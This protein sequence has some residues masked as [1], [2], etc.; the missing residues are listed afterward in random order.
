[1][2]P[3]NE[4]ATQERANET[5]PASVKG[6]SASSSPSKSKFM[7]SL[8]LLFS[9]K[10]PAQRSQ[11][12]EQPQPQAQEQT[13]AQPQEFAPNSQPQSSA[14]QLSA[15]TQPQSQTAAPSQPQPQTAAP[16]QPRP[17]AQVRQPRQRAPEDEDAESIASSDDVHF[18][19]PSRLVAHDNP[20]LAGRSK[21]R[22]VGAERTA[23]TLQKKTNAK[24]SPS[25]PSVLSGLFGSRRAES[26]K[27]SSLAKVET[28]T[29]RDVKSGLGP[30]ER[31]LVYSS[32]DEVGG[33]KATIYQGQMPKS[34]IEPVD[35]REVGQSLEARYRGDPGVGESGF[36]AAGA[37]VPLVPTQ[38]QEQEQ[39]QQQQKRVVKRRGSTATES[40]IGTQRES[41]AVSGTGRP[42]GRKLKKSRTVTGEGKEAKGKSGAALVGSKKV[43]NKQ[44]S[45]STP[46]GSG[47]GYGV[48][49]V[50]GGD[51]Q[52][53]PAMPV[54]APAL[55]KPK[56]KEVMKRSE[57]EG[58]GAGLV[59]RKSTVKK[60]TTAGGGESSTHP[61]AN[62]AS[63]NPMSGNPSSYHIRSSSHISAGSGLSNP[64]AGNAYPAGSSGPSSHASP[65]MGI[66]RPGAH[67]RVSA[68]PAHPPLNV[69]AAGVSHPGHSHPPAVAVSNHPGTSA[70][71]HHPGTSAAAPPRHPARPVPH[72]AATVS[73]QHRPPPIVTP[74]HPTTSAPAHHAATASHPSTSAPFR[75]AVSAAQPSSSAPA[76]HHAATSTAPP[77]TG[78]PPSRPTSV[79]AHSSSTTV[80]VLPAGGEHPSGTLSSGGWGGS[81]SGLSRQSSVLSASSAPIGV[82]RGK[83]QATLGQGMGVGRRASVG[84]VPKDGSTTPEGQK[85]KHKRSLS[86]DLGSSTAPTFVPV[87]KEKM[88]P[89]SVKK[90]SKAEKKPSA[91]PRGLSHMQSHTHFPPAGTTSTAQSLM[92]IVA[93]VARGNRESW[94][95]GEESV[96]ALKYTGGME[97][98]IGTMQVEVVRAPPRM[99]REALLAELTPNAKAGIGAGSGARVRGEGMPEVPRAPPPVTVTKPGPLSMPNSEPPSRERPKAAPAA[100]RSDTNVVNRPT[101]SPLRSAL[102]SPSRDPSP[103]RDAPIAIAVQK[104][105]IMPPPI[106]SS[107]VPI[108]PSAPASSPAAQGTETLAPSLSYTEASGHGKGKGE[109]KRKEEESDGVS[110]SSYETGH[111]VFVPDGHEVSRP[112]STPNGSA[113]PQVGSSDVSSSVSGAV[114]QQ[115]PQ[116]TTESESTP[117][118]AAPSPRRRKSVR[119]SLQPTFSPTP[120]AIDYDDDEDEDQKHAPWKPAENQASTSQLPVQ[121]SQ[122]QS[123]PKPPID[124]HKDM[125]ADSDDENDE[126][127]NAK[128]LLARAARKT[129]KRT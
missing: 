38:F 107:S 112:Q 79:R 39:L 94:D 43:K 124:V 30:D 118:Q 123:E 84:G 46:P 91:P 64:P 99:G 27:D 88:G 90:T 53:V 83:A 129:S 55:Q 102:K 58:G 121:P 113:N 6:S 19:A 93:N 75:P 128:L 117:R 49:P 37:P 34:H 76:P 86:M 98:P 33:R 97:R 45:S 122:P 77:T 21:P 16:T 115:P 78:A 3:V 1:V 68:G 119:V 4:P 116:P 104:P 44:R 125:W 106:A 110:I 56:E 12:Q 17:Q 57:S 2:H 100:R 96:R 22:R 127:R 24:S 7:G 101:K 109:E 32:D 18:P 73:A 105:Q 40:T 74:S 41:D 89:T 111:E 47:N 51:V 87:E 92:S 80:H 66:S 70:A 108:P 54:A 15:P 10:P 26:V 67:S 29:D 81:G 71:S 126:Y 52:P 31:W 82:E 28:R 69:A 65:G 103:P 50:G 8:R 23:S 11:A 72:H 114:Q 42:G 36:G 62:A 60:T 59:R 20:K 25:K 13:P 9:V 35:L 63:S 14:A 95:T 48:A 85:P 61:A 120:P 5:S